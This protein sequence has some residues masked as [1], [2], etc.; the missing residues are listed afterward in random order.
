MTTRA[1]IFPDRDGWRRL[2]YTCRAGWIDWGHAGRGKPHETN[3]ISGLNHQV[4]NQRSNW[5]GL[6]GLDIH[7]MGKPSFVIAYGQAMG[8][9]VRRVPLIRSTMRHFVVRRGLAKAQR[10]QV[11]L[12][13]FMS[14]SRQFEALQA[15]SFYSVF[16]NSGFSVED[17]VSNLVGFFGALRSIPEAQLRRLCRETSPEI[18][19]KV[20][21]NNTP[22][23]F[24][25]IKNKSFRPR[26]FHCL[27][28][29][30]DTEFP[31]AIAGLRAEPQGPLYR[32]PAERFIDGRLVNARRPIAMDG[33][34]RVRLRQ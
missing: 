9:E 23:G 19:A 8:R 27:E 10:E 14:T 17:L 34:G 7:Y 12:G 16:T 3:S 2:S 15:S 31:S 21:D 28:C 26:I 6:D 4:M 24:G 22:N 13:I 29:G 20:W 33:S 11:A 1:D 18:S 5:P 32:A 25:S 30:E